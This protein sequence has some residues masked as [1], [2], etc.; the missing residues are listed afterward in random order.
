MDALTHI[1]RHLG[2]RAGIFA[3]ARYCG[4]WAV[5]TS[6]SRAATFHLVQHGETWL[7][8][9]EQE[10]RQLGPG[11]LVM[12][13]RDDAH[14]IAS[15]P[16]PFAAD[17]VNRAIPVETAPDVVMLCGYF[18]FSGRSAWPLLDSL[19]DA[20]IVSCAGDVSR[21]CRTSALLDL[22]A[23]ELAAA[24]PG[25]DALIESYAHAL[26]IHVIRKAIEDGL[27]RG[28]LPAL[29]DPQIG[30][31]L[32]RIHAA[33][34]ETWTV[35]SLADEALLGR[36]AFAQRF[37]QLTDMTPMQYLTRWRMDLA[38]ELLG[39]THLSMATIA[40]RCGYGSEVAFR[41]AFRKVV[42]EP[43]GAVRRARREAA[44]GLD[45]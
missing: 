11:D 32:N 17:E 23:D 12:F 3:H 21:P 37:R 16:E 8:L 4:R 41:K 30:R 1:L 15:D 33:P 39:D 27:V 6:G 40:E 28:M 43:P 31:A 13:P 7:Q 34:E 18:A 2:L 35:E 26:F 19:P 36:T 29:T 5:D 20:V 24:Q 22:I 9:P 25:S 38:V 45:P 14:L 10:P 44:A 42:G